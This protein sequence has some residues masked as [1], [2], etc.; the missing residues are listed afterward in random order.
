MPEYA[1][2]ARKN[3]Y[4]YTFQPCSVNLGLKNKKL[5]GWKKAVTER[6]LSGY[7]M[8]G[9]NGRENIS[10]KIPKTSEKNSMS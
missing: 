4:A 2:K 9:K 6:S 1:D 8:Q 3:P 5:N 10:S 7:Y